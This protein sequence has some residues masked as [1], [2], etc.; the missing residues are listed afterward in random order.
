[1]RQIVPE[2]RSGGPWLWPGLCFVDL[3]V[4]GR[5]LVCTAPPCLSFGFLLLPAGGEDRE[6]K[7]KKK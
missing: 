5:S 6:S 1:M 2:W 4:R 7:C 3:P